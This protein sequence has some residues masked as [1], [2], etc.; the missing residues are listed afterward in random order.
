M[1]K[2]TITL[3]FL[4]G[5]RNFEW[6]SGLRDRGIQLII[7]YIVGLAAI[8]LP[9]VSLFMTFAVLGMSITFYEHFED[10]KLL[11]IFKMPATSF[12]KKKLVMGVL[13]FNTAISILTCFYTVFHPDHIVVTIIF[14]VLST[15]IVCHVIIL[16]YTFYQ[17]NRSSGGNRLANMMA[18]LTLPFPFLI[19]LPLLMSI[20]NFKKAVKNLNTYLYDFGSESSR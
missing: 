7:I 13:S 2:R 3:S 15:I 8:Q 18:I 20:R 5:S 17:P 14:H 19:P 9:F 16:K 1:G 10:Y 6:K 12:L 4:V 11:E